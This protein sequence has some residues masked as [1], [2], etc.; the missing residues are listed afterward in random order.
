[1]DADAFA[2]AARL[3]QRVRGDPAILRAV[4]AVLWAAIGH[5]LALADL[6]WARQLWSA[7]GPQMLWQVLHEAGALVGARPQ[8]APH[9]LAEVLAQWAEPEAPASDLPAHGT[10]V[11]TLPKSH[12]L[13]AREGDS[14]RRAAVALIGAAECR[15]TLC[16]PYLDVFGIGQ[17]LDPLRAAALRGVELT[18]ITSNL[19]LPAS[20]N[21]E[22]IARLRQELTGVRAALR[23]Y[24]THEG[25]Q[26]KWSGCFWLEDVSCVVQV[27]RLKSTTSAS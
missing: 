1:M 24:S 26:M 21:A 5:P 19:H 8:L 13:A 27:E 20:P 23:C 22:A 3:V 2:S 7:D 4:G 6:D 10:I 14:L 18:I 17:L 15:L 9:P 11:C 25:E 16:T 12:P